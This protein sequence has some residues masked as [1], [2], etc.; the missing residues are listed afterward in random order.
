LRWNLREMKKTDRQT[1]TRHLVK[2]M[3]PSLRGDC[4]NSI[5]LPGWD[6]A[7][8]ALTAEPRRVLKHPLQA[9]ACSTLGL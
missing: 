5:R 3:H 7:A 4:I 8:E 2:E 9:K 1:A 6:V